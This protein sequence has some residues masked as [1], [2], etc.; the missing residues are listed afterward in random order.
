MRNFLRILDHTHNT[1][2]IPYHHK[3]IEI[4]IVYQNDDNVLLIIL[5]G[6]FVFNFRNY[7]SHNK[8]DDNVLQIIR[9]IKVGQISK[10]N[11]TREIL[12]SISCHHQYNY[13]QN[14]CQTSQL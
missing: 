2:F 4:D 3:R 14:N 8:K 11:N 13:E 7:F 1:D 12:T 6:Y 10:N 9:A 5:M